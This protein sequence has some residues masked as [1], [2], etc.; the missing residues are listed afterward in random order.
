[1]KKPTLHIHIG[2]HKT[3]TT[4]IQRTFWDNSELLAKHGVHYPKTN[5]YHY[6]QHRLAFA[7]KG[8]RDPQRG[9]FPQ[10]ENEVAELRLAATRASLLHI[11]ISSE[12]FFVNSKDNLRRLRGALD[13]AD[14][15]IIA[16]VRRQDSYLLS[17]YNQ[18]AKAIGN[19]FTSP[20]KKHVEKPRGISREISF[21]LWMENWVS[22]FGP[23]AVQ[24]YRYEDDNPLHAILD[25]L[26][27]PE[28]LM[29]HTN[30]ANPSAP[31]AVIEAVR[32][33]KR[34]RLPRSMQLLVRKTAMRFFANGRMLKLSENDRNHILAEFAEDNKAMFAIFGMENT[35]APAQS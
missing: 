1:M 2:A 26:K 21:L 6:A 13:F 31:A 3:A 24:L 11:F 14:V 28:T 10:L 7:L 18:N 15:R 4:T 12:A 20:L 8:Q 32:F 27:L 25:H 22:V 34:L 30:F 16:F 33:S 23:Q 9:D 35:Y 5:R 29:P 17:L 19:S